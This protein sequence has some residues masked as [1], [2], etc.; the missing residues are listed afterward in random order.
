MCC[1]PQNALFSGYRLNGGFQ[2]N[3]LFAAG[4]LHRDH[5]LIRKIA[6]GFNI[7][8]KDGSYFI[9]MTDESFKNLIC[10]YLRP[11]TRKLLFGE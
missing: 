5:D 8:P 6:G 4:F 7:G 10:E 3:V 9:S 2:G 1:P 11:A